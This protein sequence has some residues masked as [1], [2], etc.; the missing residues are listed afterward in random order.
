MLPNIFNS[1][2]L[3]FKQKNHIN[4]QSAYKS[5]DAKMSVIPVNKET[6][7]ISGGIKNLKNGVKS[8]S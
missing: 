2:N 6:V 4:L 3:F 8:N 1:L 7:I 5:S